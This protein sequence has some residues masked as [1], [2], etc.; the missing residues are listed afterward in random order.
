MTGAAVL[1]ALAHAAGSFGPGLLAAAV[2]TPVAILAA[3]AIS[4]GRRRSPALM[5]LAPLPALAAALLAGFGAP[6]SYKSRAFDVTLALDAPGAMLLGAAALLWIGAAFYAG[7]DGRGGDGDGR[8]RASWLLT[9]MGSLGVFVASDL[10]TFFLAFALVSLPAYGLIIADDN[11][12]RRAGAV[13]MAFT[14]AGETLLLMGF[15]L[16]AAGEP[17]GSLQIRDVVAALP[18][19][20]WGG[21]ALALVVAGFVMKIGLAP[22]HGW[23]PLAYTAA[24]LPAAAVLSGAAVKAGVIGLIRFLPFSHALPAWGEGLAILGLFS[25]FYGV[26]LGIT[27]T[28]PK[29]ILAY[30]SVSQMGV[31]AAVAGMG[32]ASGDLRAPLDTAFYAAHHVLVKGALFLAIGACAAA[33]A[34]RHWLAFLPA[35]ALALSLAGLPFTGGA[36]AKLAVK[37]TLGSGAIGALASFSA[38]GT[39]LLMLH[40]L[41]RLARNPSPD[42]GARTSGQLLSAWFAMALASILAPW[43][44]F[45]LTGGHLSDA[46]TPAALRESLWPMLPGAALALPLWRWGGRLPHPPAGDIVVIGEKIIRASYGAGAAL[47]RVE[48]GIRQ[49]PAAAMALLGIAIILGAAMATGF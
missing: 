35:A 25:A 45:P 10:L 48:A 22:L 15:V 49:W 18:G 1:A 40:F 2:G 43:L 8:F 47:E 38:A 36:L 39:T 21:A 34:R 42:R 28:N 23:M 17:N 5:V 16:L 32:L 46:L 7:A 14:V 11:A 13:Y 4:R 37:G 3:C 26:A 27:Q 9:L 29:T 24:P 31:I 41:F 6:F 30:S 19:S 12:S 44:L 33:G 20:P